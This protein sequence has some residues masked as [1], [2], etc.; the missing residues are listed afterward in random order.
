LYPRPL[1]LPITATI[2]S[3]DHHDL[4]SSSSYTI[5]SSSSS[6]TNLKFVSLPCILVGSLVCKLS[7]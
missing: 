6:S 1:L 7:T 5:K 3:F 4:V 2:I